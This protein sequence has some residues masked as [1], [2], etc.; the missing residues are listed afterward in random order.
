MITIGEGLS[1]YRGVALAHAYAGGVGIKGIRLPL[2]FWTKTDIFS[3][4]SN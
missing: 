3:L 2:G 1:C 4:P